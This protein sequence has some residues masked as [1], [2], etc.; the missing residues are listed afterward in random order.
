MG[1]TVPD[2]GY[3]PV[4]LPVAGPPEAAQ[5]LAV[6]TEAQ[7]QLLA[8]RRLDPDR[9]PSG[10]Y[11]RI[12]DVRVS[13]SDPDATPLG[14]GDDGR[15]GYHDHDVVDGGKARIIL[16]AL[17]TPADVQDN[18]AMLDLLDR[19]RF[20]YHLHVRRAVADSK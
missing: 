8:E 5:Q 18:Q 19:V 16:A 4:S 2:D 1:T 17:V 6:E 7:W 15:L 10:P 13:T 12:T 11:R 20:R 3:G 14:A 9:P